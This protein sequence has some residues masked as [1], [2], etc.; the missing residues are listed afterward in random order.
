MGTQ[1]GTSG[2]F[3]TLVTFTN[4]ATIL[5]KTPFMLGDVW[6]IDQI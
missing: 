3:A 1:V 4:K 5:I 6:I 2:V